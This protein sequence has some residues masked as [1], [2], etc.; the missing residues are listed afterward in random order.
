LAYLWPNWLDRPAL[1]RITISS[2]EL[3]KP[4]EQLNKGKP[5]AEQIK[6]F[7]FLLSAQVAP[8]GY[9]A[10]VDPAHFHLI[11]PYESDPRRWH[12]LKWAD[13]YSSKPYV[14]TTSAAALYGGN[15]V[16]VKTYRDVVAEYGTHPEAKSLGP[17]GKVCGRQTV[18]LLQ[19][20]PVTRGSLTWL[21]KESNRL[22]E[23]EAG[24]VH[25]PEEVYT[26]YADPRE[27]LWQT[28]V[29]PV[30]RQMPLRVLAEQ[31]GLSERQ[32][33]AI[34][35]GHAMPR[36]KH[37]QALTRVVREYSQ[38]LGADSSGESS[39]SRPRA[40]YPHCLRAREQ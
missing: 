7:N 40:I 34:R 32:V 5:Y 15:T 4:F 6:P 23:V 33:R 19:R 31:A 10:C 35:N 39:S 22:E 25:D 8:L 9:P 27:D 12:K 3:L 29:L 26:E 38:S 37:R 24:L 11:A 18:G 36:E 30:L 21:G 13:R 16:R 17:D 14:I 2:P 1:S 20:R 28:T